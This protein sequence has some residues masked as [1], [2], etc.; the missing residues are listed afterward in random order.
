MAEHLE[1]QTDMQYEASA[2]FLILS[3]PASFFTGNQCSQI[4]CVY[5]FVSFQT[6]FLHTQA[7]MCVWSFLHK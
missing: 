4:L 5:L 1:V 2:P 6:Y 3:H 7:N